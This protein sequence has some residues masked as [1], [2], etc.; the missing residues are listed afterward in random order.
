MPR[1]LRTLALGTAA[2]LAALLA[3]AGP[4]SAHVT[5]SAPGAT[6]GG[7]DQQITF[8]VPVEENSPT[9]AF[10]V[11]LPLDHPI[12]SVL[13]APMPGWTHTEQSKHLAHPIRTDDGEIST[14]VSQ[15]TW[16]ASPGHELHPGE[17]GS[18]TVLAGQLPD[19]PTLTFKAVQ[20]YASGD[21]VRWIEVPAPGSHSQPEHPAPVLELSAD[22]TPVTASAQPSSS[23]TG[24]IV[25]A[26]IALVVAA[27]ALGF[28]VVTRARTRAGGDT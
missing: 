20:T 11:A 6:A 14:A 25:L 23:D 27:A 5:V 24:A 16:K 19:V 28:A 2:A 15:I 26:V 3:L 17:Y 10:T 22:S 13:V 9:V 8:R 4:A 7:S 21:V 1:R 18:F 12:A